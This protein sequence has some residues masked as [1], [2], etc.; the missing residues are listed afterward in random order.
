MVTT[1]RGP[2]TYWGYWRMVYVCCANATHIQGSSNNGICKACGERGL[3]S[4]V[5]RPR[6][7]DCDNLC[8]NPLEWELK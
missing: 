4:R 5:G 1:K 2:Q 6:Y 8:I 3:E 7:Y